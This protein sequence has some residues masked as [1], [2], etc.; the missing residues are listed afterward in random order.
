[1]VAPA[2][3][4]TPLLQDHDL[5]HSVHFVQP[6]SLDEHSRR[7]GCRKEFRHKGLSIVQVRL[8][9]F[10]RLAQPRWIVRSS[11]VGSAS[12]LPANTLSNERGVS[13]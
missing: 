8:H 13:L 6:V 7:L 3:D 4:H 11:A 2:L 1:M 10:G 12:D 9:R 5:I